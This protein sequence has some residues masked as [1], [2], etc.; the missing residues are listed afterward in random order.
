MNV[1]A[2]AVPPPVLLM[3]AE[4]GVRIFTPLAQP[5]LWLI[6]RAVAMV[7]PIILSSCPIA[8]G[9][10]HEIVV[11]GTDPVKNTMAFEES[12]VSNAD[13]PL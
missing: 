13:E 7:G 5:A 4:V 1:K 8:P 2:A 3:L 6:V 10:I 9:L 12:K 11:V